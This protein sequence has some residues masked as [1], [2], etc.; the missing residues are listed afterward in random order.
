MCCS[1]WADGPEADAEGEADGD[2]EGEL[3]EAPLSRLHEVLAE[4]SRMY[5]GS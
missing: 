2:G 4:V 3:G 1:M 5:C